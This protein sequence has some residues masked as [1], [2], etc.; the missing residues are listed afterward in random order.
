[1]TPNLATRPICCRSDDTSRQR[2]FV[3]LVSYDLRGQWLEANPAPRTRISSI[4]SAIESNPIYL[5]WL[6]YS[7]CEDRLFGWVNGM[8]LLMVS[9]MGGTSFDQS[10]PR[11]SRRYAVL[12]TYLLPSDLST[13][14]FASLHAVRSRKQTAFLFL[15]HI[16][17]PD[18]S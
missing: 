13:L 12:F 2:L 9:V 11:P 5:E 18:L 1:M 10:L 8:Y 4:T 15:L 3:A 6:F 16:R 14:L 7:D 17:Q